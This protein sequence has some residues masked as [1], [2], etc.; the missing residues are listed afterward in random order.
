ME[1]Q[2]A[3]FAELRSCI[4][5]GAGPLLG[6]ADPTDVTDMLVIEDDLVGR[7]S[8]V[9]PEMISALNSGDEYDG[10]SIPKEYPAGK[11]VMGMSPREDTDG[12]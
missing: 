1:L 5:E 7:E 2:L 8:S 12:L 10:M 9:G 4:W 6:R 3:G 11:G